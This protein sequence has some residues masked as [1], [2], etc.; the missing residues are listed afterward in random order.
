[1]RHSFGNGAQLVKATHNIIFSDGEKDP[2]RVGGVPENASLIGDGT[3]FHILIAGAGH[4]EDLRFS[5]PR[6]P[7]TVTAAKKKELET[8]KEWIQDASRS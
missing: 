1:M 6:D 4:H 7:P 8:I 2:W 5:D 3:V